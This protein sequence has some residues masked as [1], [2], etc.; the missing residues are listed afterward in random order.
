VLSEQCSA[1]RNVT[2]SSEKYY[3]FILFSFLTS[4][5]QSDGPSVVI[6]Q[7]CS[8]NKTDKQALDLTHLW[9]DGARF[10]VPLDTKEVTPETCFSAN[11]LGLGTRK[12]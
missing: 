2:G 10:H 3:V 11:L 7:I 9:M 12:S 1:N 5:V 6:N 4:I 8:D